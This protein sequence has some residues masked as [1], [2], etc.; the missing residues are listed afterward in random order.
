MFNLD[1]TDIDADLRRGGKE[2]ALKLSQ[3]ETSNEKVIFVSKAKK[4]L[5]FFFPPSSP[6]SLLIK[7]IHKLSAEYN[8]YL[9]GERML[10]NRHE[11][12]C[13]TK[14]APGQCNICLQRQT[15]VIYR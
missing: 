3:N 9:L 15:E 11:C 14:L 1:L 6:G 7:F 2:R 10:P 13:Y 5:Q 12:F 8:K 4:F